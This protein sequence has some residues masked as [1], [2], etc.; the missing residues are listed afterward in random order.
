MLRL[1]ANIGIMLAELNSWCLTGKDNELNRKMENRKAPQK[2][3][4]SVST[5]LWWMAAV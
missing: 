1:N 2:E 5:A 4:Q 3:N